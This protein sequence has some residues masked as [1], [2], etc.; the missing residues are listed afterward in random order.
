MISVDDALARIFA[1]T[2]PLGTETVSLAEADG[3]VL[4]APAQ[5]GRDQPP[6]AASSMD[7]YAVQG[8][9]PAGSVLRVIGK[10]V[11]GRGFD[12]AVGPGEAVRIF[13]GAPVP[14]GADRVVIQENVQ[15]AEDRATLLT[16]ASGAPHIR[17]QAFD[18]QK[19]DSL[20]APRR[21]RPVDVA[22][23]AAMNVPHVVVS[24][25]PVVAII[26]T[27]DELVMPGEA[28]G[29]DQIIASNGFALAAM[30]RAEGA[31]PRVLPIARDKEASLRTVLHL[32]SGADMIVTIG[33]ASV[34]DHDLV[35]KVTADM[36]ASRSFYKIAMRPGK[37][38]MAG[39]LNGALLLSLPGNPVSSI[40]CG[41]LFMLPALR[42]MLGL[43]CWPAPTQS[44][45]LGCEVAANG[46]RAHYMRAHLH[47]GE[48]GL[49]ITPFANQ[50]SAVLSLLAEADALLLR[51]P[52]SA[53]QPKGAEA[54]YI[55]LHGA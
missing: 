2:N 11:A 27:G 30:V 51:P 36:G 16:D 37:P 22:L 8:P 7:G 29:P 42:A 20:S 21:L 23:L 19:G 35:D 24:R 41:H 31:T 54:R 18:F 40:V 26:A 39:Q 47:P 14:K 46:P 13:T 4:R 10:A 28:P 52:H 3:R 32:A 34:G 33:G 12:G 53:A 55:P 48:D 49:E 6:F 9:A 1:L 5:A 17:P 43:G 15:A 45:R 50:D 25:K 38:L 44:A